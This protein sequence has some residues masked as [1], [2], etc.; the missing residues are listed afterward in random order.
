MTPARQNQAG[1][2]LVKT[3]SKRFADLAQQWSSASGIRLSS[4]GGLFLLFALA[5][6]TAIASM[7]SLGLSGMDEGIRGL[8]THGLVILNGGEILHLRAYL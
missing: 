2:Q 7:L 3:S 4:D 8:L 5:L 6:I 1:G